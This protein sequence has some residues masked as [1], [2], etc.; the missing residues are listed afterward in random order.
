MELTTLASSSRGNC[1]IL[2][3][4]TGR[5]CLLDCGLKFESITN[6]KYFS[7]FSKL[8]FVFV[9]HEHKD[10][11]KSLIDFENSGVECLS[12]KN[13]LGVSRVVIG[14]W[15]ICPFPVKHNVENYG[16]IIYNKLEDKK[17]V[18]ATDFVEMPKIQNVDYWL[19]E[20]NYDEFTVDK[21]IDSQDISKLHVANNIQWHNS[22]ENAL[23]Y[24]KSLNNRPKLIIA[25]HTS[26]MGGTKELI[27]KRLSKL[28]DRVEIATRNQVIE[29]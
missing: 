26:E 14:D 9:S 27:K 1:Y 13:L 23:E 24:F 11:S 17:I 10:H 18:Y 6:S 12:Y 7:S 8:D 3:S 22:L 29:F 15:I 21:I 25:C 2:K 5:F 16:A 28:C 19:Y 20:I 4:N